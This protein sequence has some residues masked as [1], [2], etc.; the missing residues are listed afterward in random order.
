MYRIWML[1]HLV[2]AADTWVGVVVALVGL[3]VAWGVYG[4]VE[5][6]EIH[7]FVEARPALRIL[8]RILFNRYY[9]D[10]LYDWIAKYIVLGIANIEQAFDAYVVDGIVNGVAQAVTSFGSGLRH[11]ETGRVQSYMIAFFGGVA[12]FAVFVIVLV[13][14][15]VK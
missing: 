13:T 6:A 3:G 5:L 10:T 7:D 14:M 9:I 1:T 15:A 4:R 2:F 11:V 12:V 8:H